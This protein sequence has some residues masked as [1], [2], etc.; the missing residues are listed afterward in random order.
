MTATVVPFAEALAQTDA[1]P[2]DALLGNG[3][4][5]AAHA[6]FAYAGLLEEA[7]LS[8]DVRAIFAAARTTNFEA[9]MRYWLA[10]SF[11]G[12]P[13]AAAD[14][15]DKVALLKRAL[16]EAVHR[17]HPSRRTAI[18]PS[19]WQ[20]CEQFLTHFI[21]RARE[22]RKFGGRIFTTNYDLLLWWAVT[23]DRGR[24]KPERLFKGHDG[25]R[26]AQYE[27]LESADLIYL[28][29]ALHLFPQGRGVKKLSYSDADGALH[30]Q[31]AAH[32]KRG[33]FP[34]FVSEGASSMKRPAGPGY[35]SDALTKFKYTC[36]S[37]ERALFTLG[38]GLGT[39][40][41]HI[42]DW[43][44]DGKINRVYLGA[45]GLAEIETFKAIADAWSSARA[46][47]NKPKLDIKLYDTTDLVWGPESS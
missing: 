27:G 40:D 22:R 9:V 19:R 31:V 32:L 46:A 29:G 28:H 39:E 38:H 23:P 25:F 36:R 10:E 24:I 16:V 7:D 1:M 35:L 33:A 6:P 41:N 15:R 37:P 4:S 11:G 2:R 14:A 17:V 34:L 18:S 26:Q 12:S 3:F 5:I 30:D 42:L 43:V 47:A 13:A 21:G 44:K 20:H 45:H 8:A